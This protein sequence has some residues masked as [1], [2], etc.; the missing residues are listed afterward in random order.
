MSE[1]PSEVSR[2]I[3]ALDVN[4][5]EAAI[6]MASAVKGVVNWVKIGLE[7]INAQEAGKVANW[8]N[9]NGFMIFWDVKLDDI[10]T[11]MAR[12]ALAVVKRFDVDVINLHA[13]SDVEGMLAVVDAVKSEDSSV[14]VIAVTE[15]SSKNTETC[16]LNSGLSRNA[17]IIH[18]AR[19]ARYAGCD[20][21]V[22]APTDLQ[23]LAA[24]SGRKLYPERALGVDFLKVVP[25]TR[26]PGADTHDQ[27]N[28]MSQHE[29][30]LMGAYWLVIG[31]EIS[32]AISPI[33]AARKI[34]EVVSVAL[35]ERASRKAGV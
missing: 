6:R 10:P 20:G 22:C 30:V 33:E 8:A 23:L 18:S 19:M 26:L 7:L 4:T 3:L 27:K 15:L 5:A 25:G 31:R 34:N 9:E 13:S 21:I 1:S 35:T 16:E 11:T 2:I 32:A 14:N 12:A 28:V 24:V 29:A 17:S